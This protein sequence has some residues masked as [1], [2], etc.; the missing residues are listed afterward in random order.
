MGTGN[1]WALAHPTEITVGGGTNTWQQ[2]VQD[3]MQMFHDR[4]CRVSIGSRH[5]VIGQVSLPVALLL[6]SPE[7]KTDYVGYFPGARTK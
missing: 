4:P 7:E 1:I 2:A 5:C 3:L 6:L